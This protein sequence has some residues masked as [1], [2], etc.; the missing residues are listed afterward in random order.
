[1]RW[2]VIGILCICAWKVSSQK[3]S[4]VTAQQEGQNIVIYYH[5]ETNTP[6][7]V[8]LYLSENGGSNWTLVKDGLSGD[9]TAVKK[10]DHS[11]LWNVLSTREHLV[12]N[13]VVFKVKSVNSNAQLKVGQEYQGGIVAYI[14]RSGD[15]GYNKGEVHGLI[16]APQDLPK[17]YQWGCDGKQ[18]LGAD[19]RTIGTGEK[20]TLDI[21]QYGCDKAAQ[22]CWDLELNGYDDWFMPSIDELQRIYENRRE[23]GGFQDWAYWSSTEDDSSDAWYFYFGKGLAFSYFKTDYYFV[24]AVRAF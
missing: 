11:I 23:I 16:A 18:V 9:L 10:G 14:L 7:A 6:C 1:M 15:K 3:V 8:Q 12:G 19:G 2:A 5:L 24:R 21:I 4:G 20:N 22:A 17:K 13:N